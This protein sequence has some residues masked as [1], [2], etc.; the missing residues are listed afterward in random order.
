MK[1]GIR[2][3]K[4]YQLFLYFQGAGACGHVPR[5]RDDVA[6]QENSRRQELAAALEAAELANAAKSDFLSRMSTRS[7]PDERDHCMS[8]I[9]AQSLGKDEVVADCI[10]EEKQ[11][12]KKAGRD[13]I[14][15]S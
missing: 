14:L 2:R 9:A 5:G 11:R 13:T 10:Y 12:R 6:V 4:K 1:K 3:T 8:A 15:P 7:V